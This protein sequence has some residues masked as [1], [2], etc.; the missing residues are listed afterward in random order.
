MV[1]RRRWLG[2]FFGS[3]G[4][5]LVLGA[6]FGGFYLYRSGF[7][8]VPFSGSYVVRK[9]AEL[10]PADDIVAFVGV[11]VVPM[12]SERV[13]E[14]RTVVVRDGVISGI[15]ESSS[16]VVPEGARVV[17]AEGKYLMPGLADMHVH[18]EDV[19]ELL[20]FVANGVTTVR[21]MWG[22]QGLKRWMGLP[23]QLELRDE[24]G[25]GELLGP[26]IYT[27]G[28]IL[29]G[30]PPN[31]PLMQVYTDPEAAAQEVEKQ[32]EQGYDFIKVYD[33]LSPEV[34]EAI[35]AAAELRGLKVAGHVP[36]RV[37]LD[38][39]LAGGQHT[40]E[41]LTG[42]VDPDAA[43]FEVPEEDLQ[44]YAERTREAGAWNCP[45]FVIW[46]KRIPT[47][48]VV[49]Q[50]E[51]RYVSPRM[52]R[53]WRTFSGQ[54]ADS[55]TYPGDDYAERMESHM[56]TVTGALR[57]ADA[58]V[59]LGTDTDN[60]YVVPGFSVHEELRYLVGSGL[61][62]YEA[63][64]AGTSSAAESLNES[65]EFGTVEVGK[66][67]DLILL[68]A[69]PLE[70]VANVRERAGVMVRGRWLPESQLQEMLEELARSYGQ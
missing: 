57:Q 7:L 5:V 35:T 25:R 53:I 6:A 16:A 51:I 70:D 38:G 44:A 29:E 11:N 45:T 1:R 8:P 31:T 63:L 67:A 41:H 55:I 43:T 23:D 61:S 64:R 60:A 50:P 42:Y 59:L 19:D 17:R 33:N 21:N 52:Q 10:E 62:P 49:N 39:S 20:L 15:E 48:E 34:Y 47:E 2:W 65:G 4:V 13:L 18:V 58:G 46:Q 56:Q 37:G 12:D 28:P 22:N 69:N 14:D 26:S 32:A 36:H 68:D 40:I 27:S 66:R 54:M 3:A 9:S 30:S 24:I